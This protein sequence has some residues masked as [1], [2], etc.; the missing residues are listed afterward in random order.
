MATEVW[1]VIAS[2]ILNPPFIGAAISAITLV[3]AFSFAVSRPCLTLK[4]SISVYPK[5]ADY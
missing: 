1:G 2:L 5:S 3:I 4:V